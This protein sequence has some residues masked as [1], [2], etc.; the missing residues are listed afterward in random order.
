MSILGEDVR[1]QL[2][3]RFTERLTGTVEMTLYV[4]PD[5]GRLILP[6]GLGCATCG[7]ARDLAAA[8]QEA[9]PDKVELD[10]VDVTQPGAPAIED[11][12]RLVIGASGQARIAYRGL[13]TGF[14]FVTLVDAIERVSRADPGL[15]PAAFK[16]LDQVTEPVELMVFTT[17]G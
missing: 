6:S 5:S 14:E 11:V 13:P 3:A 9:A 2:R 7:A 12:P 15:S 17:P 8:L 10:V 16:L 1:E 4:R